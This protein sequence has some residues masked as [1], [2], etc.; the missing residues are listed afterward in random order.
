MFEQKLAPLPGVF[1]R[2]VRLS[3]EGQ[4][5]ERKLRGVGETDTPI[6][7]PSSVRLLRFMDVVVRFLEAGPRSM[8][9]V[10]WRSGHRVELT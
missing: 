7:H 1:T 5:L 2:S 3:N 4:T 9:E 6:A 10:V 8:C